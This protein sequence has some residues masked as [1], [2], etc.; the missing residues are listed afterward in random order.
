MNNLHV[1]LQVGCLEFQVF[2]PT[3]KSGTF[4]AM[5]QAFLEPGFQE[6]GTLILIKAAVIGLLSLFFFTSLVAHFSGYDWFCVMPD[7][8]AYG[9]T[10]TSLVILFFVTSFFLC[11]LFPISLFSIV[12]V[13]LI[14]KVEHT[15]K[16]L[17]LTIK[18]NILRLKRP[19]LRTFI[20]RFV[21]W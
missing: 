14:S 16:T 2:Y 10:H 18:K 4:H 15:Y 12:L 17:N 19:K 5:R 7:D 3:S 21:I 11:G 8:F 9:H 1:I 6:P 20:L 13:I